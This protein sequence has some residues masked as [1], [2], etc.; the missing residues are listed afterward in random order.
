MLER[1]IKHP[2]ESFARCRTCGSEPAHIESRGRSSREPVQFI[3]SAVRH[4]LE[5][6]CGARAARAATLEAAEREWGI[7][8]AQLALPLELARVRRSKRRSVA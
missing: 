6:R 5:C 1:T 7:H 3:A 2:P 4:S 8:H